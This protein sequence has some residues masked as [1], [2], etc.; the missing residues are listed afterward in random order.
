MDMKSS[1][2]TLVSLLI[3]IILVE[4][5]IQYLLGL[6]LKPDS[7]GVW[8]ILKTGVTIILCGPNGRVTRFLNVSKLTK[9]SR[10]NKKRKKVKV[11]P[12]LKQLIR[13]VV[14]HLKI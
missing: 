5:T 1:F 3:N 4:A 11:I 7:G 2:L 10:R 6:L 12:A 8:E 9:S 13:K 14:L